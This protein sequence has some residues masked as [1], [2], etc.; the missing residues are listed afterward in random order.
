LVEEDYWPLSGDGRD[1]DM[2]DGD[3]MTFSY[4]LQGVLDT[5]IS[6]FRFRHINLDSSQQSFDRDIILTLRILETYFT[7]IPHSIA[8]I[9]PTNEISPFAPMDVLCCTT[10]VT[11]MKHTTG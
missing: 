6:A 7:P 3:M 9:P 11:N 8:Q 5:A 10:H 2:T 1:E 4:I